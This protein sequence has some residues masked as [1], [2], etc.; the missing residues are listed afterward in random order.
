MTYCT[1]ECKNKECP[2]NY[3]NA[4]KGEVVRDFKAYC[5]TKVC[6]GYKRP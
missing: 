4:K 5:G 2:V 6:K 3:K 1:N